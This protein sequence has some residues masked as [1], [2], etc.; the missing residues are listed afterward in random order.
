MDWTTGQGINGP[1]YGLLA[2]NSAGYE[3]PL[4]NTVAN[5]A[6]VDNLIKYIIDKQDSAGAWGWDIEEYEYDGVTYP[7]S[8][9]LT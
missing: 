8:F 4:D 6:T 2:L 7:A 9:S 5:Q 1:V 3:I